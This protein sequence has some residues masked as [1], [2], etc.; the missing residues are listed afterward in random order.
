MPETVYFQQL[1]EMIKTFQETYIEL[2]LIRNQKR[3]EVISKYDENEKFVLIINRKG[4]K[5]LKNLSFLINSR[6]HGK[7]MVR[8]DMNGA[9]HDNPD[10]ELIPTPHIHIHD[11]KHLDG[12][13]AIPLENV[14]D[15]E[16]I[17]EL[18]ESMLFF[19]DYK[20]IEV[21]GINFVQGLEV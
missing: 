3:C 1:L 6:T 12:R 19:L 9:P 14:T 4:N 15:K 20:S 5:N 17:D 13:I 16:L 7:R 21:D 8:L 18:Y 11:E 10:G 2:P